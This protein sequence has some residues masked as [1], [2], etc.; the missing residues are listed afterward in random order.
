M[1]PL[2]FFSWCL[3][4]GLHAAVSAAEPT[5]VDLQLV[6]EVTALV[7]GKP[8][9]VGLFVKHKEGVH[10][11]WQN[12][13]IVGVPFSMTWKLP[14]GFEAG[15]IRWAPPEK[16]F[17]FDYPAHGY[18]RDVL[19]LVDITV[20]EKLPPPRESVTLSATVGLMA[21]SRFCEP[22]H[23]PVQL[24]LPVLADQ[25]KAPWNP[26][27]APVFEAA[28]Q[29]LPATHFSWEAKV[30][31]P[32]D[33]PQVVLHLIP[34]QGA[35]SDPGEVYFFSSDGQISSLPPQQIVQQ[36]DGSLRITAERAE[37]SPKGKPTLPGVLWARGGWGEHGTG[38]HY[39]A[40]TP[41]YPG[42]P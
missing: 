7:P 30:E 3:I 36:K 35:A 31:S 1:K 27:W 8:L 21:C 10:T 39:V 22:G 18:K 29:A 26:T 32:P 2:L 33:A 17:M 24:T 28:R 14:P 38:P 11:Y 15:P 41:V 16:V 34:G 37:F 5:Q 12:P 9:Q 13:G 4:A 23:Y 25:K 40:L 42:K 19:L 6:S 20:P